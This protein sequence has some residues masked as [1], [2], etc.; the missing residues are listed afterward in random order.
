MLLV[1]RF[2]R[3]LRIADCEEGGLTDLEFVL[4]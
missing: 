2:V 4:E 1:L 3:V